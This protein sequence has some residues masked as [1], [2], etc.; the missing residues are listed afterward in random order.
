MTKTLQGSKL[1]DTENGSNT[2]AVQGSYAWMNN[3]ERCA[4][5][6]F[7]LEYKTANGKYSLKMFNGLCVFMDKFD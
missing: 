5:N 3:D 6:S 2:M 1:E 4:S 7:F